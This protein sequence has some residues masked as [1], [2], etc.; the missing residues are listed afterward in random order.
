VGRFIAQRLK[1]LVVLNSQNDR[2]LL[3]PLTVVLLHGVD[4][5]QSILPGL[6]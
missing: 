6:F 3:A 2:I 5:A 1:G 4:G